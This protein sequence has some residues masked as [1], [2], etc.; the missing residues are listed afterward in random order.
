MHD[1]F[2]NIIYRLA[3][4]YEEAKYEDTGGFIPEFYELL[5]LYTKAAMRCPDLAARIEQLA[6]D[7]GVIENE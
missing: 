2:S 3:D 4:N 1:E 5:D 7:N 6:L